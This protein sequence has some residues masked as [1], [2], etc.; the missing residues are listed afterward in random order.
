M[1]MFSLFCCFLSQPQIEGTSTYYISWSDLLRLQY[2]LMGILYSK[3]CSIMLYIFLRFWIRLFKIKSF[4][5]KYSKYYLSCAF[6]WVVL[7]D[8]RSLWYV[9]KLEVYIY[10]YSYNWF[11][12]DYTKYSFQLIWIF[13]KAH[14]ITLVVTTL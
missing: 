10:E 2:F 5:F 12:F 7:W 13:L 9:W 6:E 8:K 11:T 1:I 3:I 14:S 4:R